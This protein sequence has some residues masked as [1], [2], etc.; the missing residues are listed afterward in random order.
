MTSYPARLVSALLSG[1]RA[2]GSRL[3]SSYRASLTHRLADLM[4][5]L[6]DADF[7]AKTHAEL[8]R[9]LTEAQAARRQHDKPGCACR[10]CSD[11][12]RIHAAMDDHLHQLFGTD[13]ES[14]PLSLTPELAATA[15]AMAVG[16]PDTLI[17]SCG[18]RRA[19][20]YGGARVCPT[21][22]ALP[23]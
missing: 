7:V 22:D 5:T 14:S 9:L 15:L 2:L 18:E 20:T 19:N 3:R 1:L 13:P 17:C 4:S 21:C 6:S 23:D 16:D 10:H 11:V 8:K 12:T